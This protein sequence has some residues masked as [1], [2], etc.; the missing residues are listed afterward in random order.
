MFLGTLVFGPGEVLKSFSITIIDDDIY[1]E[2]EHFFCKLSNL[3]VGQ[4]NGKYY[5]LELSSIE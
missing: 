5:I 3:R 1:E 2:D 4:A